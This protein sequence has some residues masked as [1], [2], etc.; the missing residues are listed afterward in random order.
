M[1]ALM[2]TGRPYTNTKEMVVDFKKRF[3][4]TNENT[5]LIWVQDDNLN[6]YLI[7]RITEQEVSIFLEGNMRSIS[8]NSLF[9]YYYYED[10]SPCG[11]F[12]KVRYIK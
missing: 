2:V 7:V 9:N 4:I 11:I 6:K 1:E 3:D 12:D 5:P 10:G 8:L